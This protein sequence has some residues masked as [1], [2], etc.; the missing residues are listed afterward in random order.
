MQVHCISQ[1]AAKLSH[2]RIYH[3]ANH[4]GESLMVL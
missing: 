3:N 2:G 1:L 4:L